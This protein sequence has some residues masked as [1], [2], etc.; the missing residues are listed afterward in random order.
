MSNSIPWN[1]IQP[2]TNNFHISQHNKYGIDYAEAVV[3]ATNSSSST[4]KIQFMLSSSVMDNIKYGSHFQNMNLTWV[5]F[6]EMLTTTL[7][8]SLFGNPIHSIPICGTKSSNAEKISQEKVCVKWYQ[9]GITLPVFRISSEEKSRNPVFMESEFLRKVAMKAI[10]QRYKFIP[11]YYT[12]LQTSLPFVKPMMFDYYDDLTT[13]TLDEQ[14]MV[15]SALLVAHPVYP[16]TS[17]L[18]VYLPKNAGG[19]YE[20][21]G[22]ENY[23]KDWAKINIV[24]TDVIMFVPAG[25]IIPFYDVSLSFF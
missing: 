15:G 2:K 4:N 10:E 7:S 6:K 1:A 8:T 5:A 17:S 16:E 3:E 19:W 21:W 18:K 22:G 9:A 25:H 11:Y 14:Y 24:E 12:V 20:Y 13:L 23:D